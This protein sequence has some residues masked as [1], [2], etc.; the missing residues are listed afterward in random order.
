MLVSIL[1]IDDEDKKKKK[2]ISLEA[3]RLSANF[4]FIKINK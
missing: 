1:I 4:S 2:L 3:I